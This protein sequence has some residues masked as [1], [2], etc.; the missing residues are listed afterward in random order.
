M[1]N[2]PSD[3][4][5]TIYDIVEDKQIIIEGSKYLD[6]TVFDSKYDRFILLKEDKTLEIR[7]LSDP[8]TLFK[9]YPL[10]LP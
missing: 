4:K 1:L 9:S 7:K 8:L 3:M 2:Y 5:F 10:Q 6:F